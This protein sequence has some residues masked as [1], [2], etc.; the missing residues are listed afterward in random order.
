MSLTRSATRWGSL[1]LLRRAKRSI[2]FL[3][4]AI[5]IAAIGHEM[6]RKGVIRGAANIALDATPV[7][8]AAKNLIEAFRGDFIPDR[9]PRVRPSRRDLAKNGAGL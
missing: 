8:G 5:A 3:G 6:R 9:P 1:R 7:V 2:P 4:A